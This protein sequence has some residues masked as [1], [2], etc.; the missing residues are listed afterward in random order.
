M[1]SNGDN[2]RMLWVDDADNCSWSVPPLFPSVYGNAAFQVD[3]L[4]NLLQCSHDL[5]VESCV[6]APSQCSFSRP[7]LEEQRLKDIQTP[8]VTDPDV[9]SRLGPSIC[10]S[11]ADSPLPFLS[12]Q[13]MCRLRVK[14]TKNHKTS[15]NGVRL[16][17]HE[18]RKLSHSK[19]EKR[20]RTNINEK[21]EA[22]RQ[23]IPLLYQRSM[24]R[25]DSRD[26]LNDVNVDED[27]VKI[28]LEKYGKAEILVEALAYIKQLEKNIKRLRA[29]AVTTSSRIKM[30]E[31]VARSWNV[32]S[33]YE[34]SDVAPHITEVVKVEMVHTD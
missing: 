15:T 8:N 32:V 16:P 3:D 13:H 23:G 12:L 6:Q 17:V 20:Y 2:S 4:G 1:E 10:A 19:V 27:D 31:T 9:E 11:T 18:T 26:K 24:T 33:M 7:G 21:L 34:G 14:R 30:F 22:L 5:C 25:S 29:E 28:K